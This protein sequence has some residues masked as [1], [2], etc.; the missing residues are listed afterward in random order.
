MD[1]KGGVEWELKD[2]LIMVVFLVILVVAT[3][4]L[5]KGKGGELLASIKNMMRFGRAFLVWI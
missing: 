4:F 1:K 5:L 3:I 2:I